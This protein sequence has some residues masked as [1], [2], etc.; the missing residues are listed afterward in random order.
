MRLR[1]MEIVGLFWDF[2]LS[3]SPR[4][5]YQ[6]KHSSACYFMF[7]YFSYADYKL[8]PGTHS[9]KVSLSMFHTDWHNKWSLT[10]CWPVIEITA[11]VTQHVQL[12]ET[13]MV[14]RWITLYIWL[15]TFMIFW[16]PSSKQFNNVKHK[17][18]K[19]MCC[20]RQSSRLMALPSS[21][22]RIYHQYKD[23]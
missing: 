5:S 11:A 16:I 22:C 4:T 2:Y 21:L 12:N 14:K 6:I 13:Y 1:Q 3:C 10:S 19:N 20:E 15:L 23:H 17:P 8:K 9:T 7:I 18:K